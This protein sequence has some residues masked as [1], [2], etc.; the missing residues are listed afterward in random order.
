LV[1]ERS[2]KN[3][4]LGAWNAAKEGTKKEL[5]R[6]HLRKKKPERNFKETKAMTSLE[7]RGEGLMRCPKVAF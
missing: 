7:E 4:L 5:E 2:R 3:L 6:T 1:R